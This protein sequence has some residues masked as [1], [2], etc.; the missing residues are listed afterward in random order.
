MLHS[1]RPSLF[2]PGATAW[3]MRVAGSAM[4]AVAPGIEIAA[5]RVGAP[6]ARMAATMISLGVAA[7]T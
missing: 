4:S 6:V 5:L 2:G 7:Y 1:D 3:I